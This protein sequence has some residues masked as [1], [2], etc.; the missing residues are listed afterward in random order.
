M[1]KTVSE[2]GAAHVRDAMKNEDLYRFTAGGEGI[3]MLEDK[4]TPPELRLAIEKGKEWL[5][6]PHL[7]C[8]CQFYLTAKG[9]E[10]YEMILKPLHE[11]YMPPIECEVVKR[12]TLREIVYEDEFQ[13]G[14]RAG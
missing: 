1:K 10:M 14:E 5:P 12:S 6:Q 3:F 2:N 9:K 13:V 11:A 8:E 4:L 7:D